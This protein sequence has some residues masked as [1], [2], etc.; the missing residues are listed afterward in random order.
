M[1]R[2][3]LSPHRLRSQRF[4]RFPL[5]ALALALG[6]CGG[7]P[8]HQEQ[9]YVFGTLVEVTLYGEPEPR[10]R[11]LAREVFREFQRLHDQYHAWKPSRLTA[12][13]AAFAAGPQPVPV[14]EELAGFIR[15]ATELS[16][17][18][19]GLFNPAIGRLVALWGFHGETFE[20]RLPEAGAVA[21]LVAQRPAMEDIVLAQGTAASRNPAVQ[22]DFGGYLKG[23]ALDHAARLLR[24]KGVAN[25]LIN[26]GGNV[27]ALGR[28]GDRPWRV[29]IQHPRKP[30]PI[31][32]LDLQDGEAIGTSGDYQRYF[33]LDG[34]RYCHL[35]DPRTGLPGQSAQSAT[36]LAP[37]GPDA[38]T[39]SDAASKPVFLAGLEGFPASARTMGTPA[40]LLIDAQGGLH[41]TPELEARLSL[42]DRE[43]R[44]LP[45]PP[46]PVA[47]Q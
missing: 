47:L 42:V 40:A 22:L 34:R 29:G 20:P 39:L 3:P 10:A 33:E 16:R 19:G 35:I 31:A 43:A 21:R 14:E 46:G 28:R 44:S 30:G 37:P 9:A 27:L 32:V 2:L 11:A 41:V 13:N 24:G 12:L 6:G 26:V 38:G 4:W 45:A 25:A 5:L 36:V 8:V 7:E 1:A 15:E 23:K 17:R 18:S